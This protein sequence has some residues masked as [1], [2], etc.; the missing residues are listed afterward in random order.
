LE[1]EFDSLR[2]PIMRRF[3]TDAGR[4]LIDIRYA[5]DKN[6]AQRARQYVH[7]GGRTD[8]FQYDAGY[9][10]RRVDVDAH[11]VIGSLAGDRSLP[12]FVVPAMV[13]GNWSAGPYAREATYSLTDVLQSIV[14]LNPDNLPVPPIGGGFQ[15]PDELLFVQSIDGFT[16]VRDEVGNVVVTRLFVRIP[17]NPVPVPVAATNTY[18]ELNQLVRIQRA[19]GVVIHNEYGPSGLRIRRKVA[20]DLS[21]CVPSDRAFLYDGGNLIEERDLLNGGA[22]VARYYYGDQG[23]ELIAGDLDHGSGLERHYFL[24]DVSRSVLGI[25]DTNGTLVEHMRY[26]AWGQ[27]Q[28]EAA[29]A[30]APQVSQVLKQTNSLVLQFTEPVLP[31]FEAGVSPTNIITGLRQLNSIIEVR[32]NGQPVDGQFIYEPARAGAP[33][34]SAIRFSYA[35]P[36]TGTVVLEVAGGLLQDASNNTNSEITLELNIGNDGVVFTGPG[37]GSTAPQAFDRSSIGSPFLFHGQVFDYDTGLL[38]C[39]ARFYDPASGMFLQRDPSG[40]IDGVNQ[41]AGFANNPI[42]LRDPTG[43]ATPESMDQ[44]EE[45]HGVG[46]DIARMAKESFDRTMDLGTSMAHGIDLLNSGNP[47]SQGALDAMRGAELII[48]DVQ[49]AAGAFGMLKLGLT[50]SVNLTRRAAGFMQKFRGTPQIPKAVREHLLKSGLTQIEIDAIIPAMKKHGVSRLT[51]RSFKEAKRASRQAGVNAG[52]PQKPM[53]VKDKTG[54]D[55]TVTKDGI[56]YVS[57]ADILHLEV[58]GRP[59]TLKEI[60]KFTTT[61]NRNYTKLWNQRGLGVLGVPA[62][63]PFQHGS[64]LSMGQMYE[65][66]GKVDGKYIASVGHPEDSFTIRIRGDGNVLAY[67]TPRWK[68]HQD[69]MRMGAV[70]QNRMVTQGVPPLT[71]PGNNLWPGKNWNDFR[72]DY[73]MESL[74]YFWDPVNNAVDQSK[75]RRFFGT[76]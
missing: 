29:D 49:V 61:A 33:F 12:N 75:M 43:H 32:A 56:R 55:A 40:Y 6:G 11:P 65:W 60:Q 17:G 19:D 35:G 45:T 10:F 3:L 73:V 36:L 66:G 62:N 37:I 7:R 57:D 28:I 31:S 39:R 54:D 22:V 38:Y 68:T 64:H 48:S 1:A 76:K 27:P 72:K 74:S 8:F 52:L 25:C 63:P 51:I 24:T 13:R 23:D 2:R 59:A 9:R 14:T 15:N 67:D 26:D 58:N 21:R 16:R 5:Y 18:N 30:V 50:S 20:G 34:G 47:G 4:T 42:S 44:G 46:A 71:F 41:Y 69:I 53:H 70:L